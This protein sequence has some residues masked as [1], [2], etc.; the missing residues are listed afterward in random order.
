MTTFTLERTQVVRA[1]LEQA[2][3]FYADPQNLE[4][5]TPPWLRFSIVQAPDELAEGSL[6]RYRLRLFGVPI[7]WLTEIRSWQ[8]PRSFVDR[9]LRGPYLLWEHTHRLVPA[10]SGTEIHDHVSYRVPG[11]R[12]VD[13]V[14]RRLLAAI[15]DYRASRTDELLEHLVGTAQRSSKAARAARELSSETSG[16]PVGRRVRGARATR[17]P[18]RA[19]SAK[20]KRETS[21]APARCSGPGHVEREHLEQRVP[22]GRRRAPASGSRRRRSAGSHAPAVPAGRASPPP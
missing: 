3:A 20:S 15:F 21:S 19:G 9:Q 6:L 7:N 10:G 8:P 14:V 17:G 13:V 2:W 5:I 4:A 16:R 1:P 11:G 22:R 12:L 18:R